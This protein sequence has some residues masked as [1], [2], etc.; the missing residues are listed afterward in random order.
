MMEV[1]VNVKCPDILLAVTALVSALKGQPVAQN[2]APAAVS[3]APMPA[4]ADSTPTPSPVQPA[5]VAAPVNPAPVAAPV[6][7]TPVT[8]QATA[9]YT[10]TAPVAPAPT[11][12]V[13]QI[14]KAGADLIGANSA[15][16]PQLLGLLQQFGVQAITE[17]KPD[18]LGPF[19]TALRGLGAKI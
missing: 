18:Q 4:P 15:K 16:M 13:E 8:A 5:S 6:A 10:S 14:S 2:T 19:A 9:P 7:P 17:L 12:T 3:P 11:F 1:N